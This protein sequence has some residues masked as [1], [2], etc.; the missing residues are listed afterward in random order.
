[1]ESRD[2]LANLGILAAAAAAWAVVTLVVLNLDPRADPVAGL[3]GAFAIGTATG[4]TVTPLFWL[5]TFAR[6]GRIAFRGDWVRAGRRGLWAGLV[7]GL[8]VELRVLGVLSLPIALFVVVL[9]VFAE[10][11]LTIER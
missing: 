2:R 11:T 10:I 3:L 4:L 8:L 9:V 7:A 1:M 6:H 5:A